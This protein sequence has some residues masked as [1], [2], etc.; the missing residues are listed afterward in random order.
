[1]K[2]WKKR[3]F[4]SKGMKTT[5][6]GRRFVLAAL[7]IAVAAVN[8]GNNLIYLILALMVSVSVLGVVLLKIN[9]SGLTMEVYFDGPVFAKE[10]AYANVKIKN[11]KRLV[12]SYSFRITAD[13]ASSPVYCGMIPP[14]GSLEKTVGLRFNTRGV[15]G[16][17][18]F[19]V[20]SGFPFIL[21]AARRA[22]GLS[23]ETVIYPERIDT[24]GLVAKAV[25]S[26]ESGTLV[27]T[28]SGDEMYSIRQYRYGDDWRRIHWKA[29]AKTSE[30]MVTEFAEGEYRRATVVID[31]TGEPGREG[32]RNVRG[33]RRSVHSETFEKAVSVA[34]SLTQE[35]IGMGYLVRLMSCR[36]VV[37]FGTGNDHLFR[38][39]G[40]LALLGEE[41]SWDS[42]FPGDGDFLVFVLRSRGG[43]GLPFA[44]SGTVVYADSL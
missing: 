39:L 37:P 17:R 8:T 33:R 16:S 26:P 11:N 7:L 27:K 15:H 13:G 10:E 25:G 35:L 1:M 3:P 31:N 14:G 19:F 44:P 38:V 34:G 12:P 9:L 23:G 29:T 28:A 2:Y 6:E 18:D 43:S 24:A 21:L 32:G 5:R 30:L 42:S 22:A 4:R 40:V 20:E 36:K 41:P